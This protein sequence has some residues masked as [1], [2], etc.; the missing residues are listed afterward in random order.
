MQSQLL[1]AWKVGFTTSHEVP[2]PKYDMDAYMATMF[3][4]EAWE[5]CCKLG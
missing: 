3:G 1:R 4:G 2:S 5:S